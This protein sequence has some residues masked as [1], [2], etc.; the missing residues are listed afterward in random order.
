MSRGVDVLPAAFDQ[1][2]QRLPLAFELA[3]LGLGEMPICVL[4]RKA[5]MVRRGR[6]AAGRRED[7]DCYFLIEDAVDRPEK[8]KRDEGRQEKGLEARV[9]ALA[10]QRR[11]SAHVWSSLGF[12]QLKLTFVNG[13]L[14][15][16]SVSAERSSRA[17]IPPTTSA[18]LPRAVEI[19][20]MV[21]AAS[22]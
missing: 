11:V 14:L 3:P 12:S 21:S 10:G 22:D 1:P 2:P 16:N 15:R 9:Q 6:S 7:L 19:F 18:I 20:M 17:T 8:S 5:G 4:W 13:V